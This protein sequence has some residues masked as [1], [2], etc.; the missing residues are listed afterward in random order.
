MSGGMLH[1][2]YL[3]LG[4]AA[5]CAATSVTIAATR[6]APAHILVSRVVPPVTKLPHEDAA[7]V[8]YTIKRVLPIKGAMHMGEFHWDETGA[9][10]TGRVIVT[11]DLAAQVISIFRDGYEIGTA[12]VLYGADAKPTPTGVYPITQKD[13]THVSN[14]YDAPMPYMLRL[15]NDGISIH[16]S[17]VR[18]GYTTHGC[19]GVPTAFAKK[20]FDAVK[21]G[22]TVIVTRGEKLDVGKPVTAA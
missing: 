11:V 6:P 10:S 14:I 4:V 9:P 3:A 20:L 21:L 19:I 8:A 16:A 15:T 13:A 1:P 7:S 22:D 12:A 18:D 17:E 2:S 5:M